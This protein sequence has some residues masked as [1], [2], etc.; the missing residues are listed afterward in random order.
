MRI[1]LATC[2]HHPGFVADDDGALA[3][4]MRPLG[5]TATPAIWSDPNIDWARFDACLIRTTWDY[6]DRLPAFL[7]WLRRIERIV[8]TF[9]SAAIAEVNLNKRYLQRLETAGTPVVETIWA[10]GG[11]AIDLPRIIDARRW[12]TFVIKPTV[13]A[14]ADGLGLFTTDRLEE[15]SAHA[16]RLLQR[17]DIMIQPFLKSILDR[18]ELSLVF[19]DGQ[20]THAVRKRAAAG[21]F[22]VQIEF[23]GRYTIEAPDPALL[24]I[25]RRALT[26]WPGRPLYA[27]VDL[28]EPEPGKS[29][30]LEV[31]LVE[32]ELFFPW[33]AHAGAALGSALRGRLMS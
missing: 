21:D 3:E 10:A 16:A 1:A 27:R 17:G 8:P 7:D 29:A 19:I 28:V 14:G 23:G 2:E 31:E 20:F 12:E 22:R 33:A 9:N 18:G 25:A 5:I 15:A 11:E 6:M 4:A 13:G 26:G 24:D 30:V 32:P